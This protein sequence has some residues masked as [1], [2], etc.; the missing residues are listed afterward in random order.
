MCLL[1]PSW[2]TPDWPVPVNV[3]SAF[4]TRS[5]GVSYAP[6]NSNN[7]GLHVDD[8][9]AAVKTNRQTLMSDLDL[10]QSPLWLDQCHGTDVIY[11]PDA[12]HCPRADASYTDQV[13]QASVVLT[14]D[15]LPVLFCN[16]QGTQVAA[17]H[18]GWRGLCNGILRKAVARFEL[19]EDVIACLGPAIG[20][21]AFEVGAEVLQAF[22]EHSQGAAQTV[23]IEQAFKPL[24]S[25]KYLADLYALAR[26]DLTSCG[27]T[28]IYGGD[29]C[30]F[31]DSERFYS[32][33]REARTGRQASLI[34]LKSAP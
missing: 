8:D 29:Y 6:Y 25:G 22:V 18:A 1:M 21:Q 26:A 19:A 16:R 13:G 3:G 14:A 34:W 11:I 28:Q 20:P 12:L 5:G 30:T 31:S 15:C 2:L 32:Y 7:L 9:P 4:T 23:Q 24:G 17:A 33:R 27:V 10:G